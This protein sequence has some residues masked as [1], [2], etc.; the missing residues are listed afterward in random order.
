MPFKSEAQR[1]LFHAKAERGEISEKKVH[2][3][4]HETPKKVKEHLPYHV[5]KS[6]SEIADEILAKLS[7]LKE[8]LTGRGIGVGMPAELPSVGS[9]PQTPLTR[10][11]AVGM[12]QKAT[13]GGGIGG[14]RSAGGGSGGMTNTASAKFAEV[15]PAVLEAVIMKAQSSPSGAKIWQGLTG[16]SDDVLMAGMRM[17]DADKRSQ[18]KTAAHQFVSSLSMLTKMS[19]VT[20][21]EVAGFF[22]QNPNPEDEQLHAWAE[23]KGEKPDEVEDKAYELATA[24]AKKESKGDKIEGG[25]ADDKSPGDFDSKQIDM[26]KKVEKEHTTD[27]SL[28]AEIAT[29]HLEEIPD[30]YTRLKKMEDAALKQA[31]MFEEGPRMTTYPNSMPV[32]PMIPPMSL[33][34]DIIQL[35]KAQALIDESKMAQI[36]DP[37]DGPH[38]PY[39]SEREGTGVQVPMDDIQEQMQ[40]QTLYDQ[41]LAQQMRA[42]NIE[43]EY[44]GK[45]RRGE[46]IGGVGGLLG[47]GGLG[48]L[49]SSGSKFHVPAMVVGA[50]VGGLL[51]KG[52]GQHI[53]QRQGLEYLQNYT[54]VPWEVQ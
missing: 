2:E 49:F 17:R 15:D 47:G 7:S 30:Y 22:Q 26:G 24:E 40:Q 46:I 13:G 37:G 12:G 28:A 14:A 43:S 25:K 36:N 44:K 10:G 32:A 48:H 8:A 31:E 20:K 29:D 6:S 54:G 51:G 18:Q 50:G 5:K 41:E 21:K 39:P 23:G 34:P 11:P 9:M 19:E 16:L 35:L 4:E 3:W 42:Q 53:G 33:P 45:V 1:R 38:L 52:V 27:P